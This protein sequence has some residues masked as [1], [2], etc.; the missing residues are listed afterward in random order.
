MDLPSPVAG[1]LP[2]TSSPCFTREGEDALVNP[3][4]IVKA[5]VQTS[6]VGDT[7]V[8]VLFAV[9]IVEKD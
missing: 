5:L 2:T 4:Q 7:L 9:M 6:G 8:S 3:W 1:E